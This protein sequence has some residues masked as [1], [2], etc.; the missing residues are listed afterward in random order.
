MGLPKKKNDISVYG[1]PLTQVSEIMDRR[2][3]LLERITNSDTF[4]PESILHDDL[5]AGMLSYIKENLVVTS[6]GDQIP[7]IPRI[8]T[9]QRWGEYTN[10]WTF[11]DDSG[12]LKLP[13]I[14]IV[15][16]PE[17]KLGTNP[18]VQ[19]TIPDRRQIFYASVPTWD[20]N[21]LGA[22]IYKIP[23]PIAVDINYDIYIVCTS[24]RDTNKF[25]KKIMELFPSRQSYTSVKGHYIPIVLEGIDDETPMETIDDRRF[26][27]QRYSFTMLG[28]LIDDEEFEVQPA[29]NRAIMMT[30]FDLDS[31]GGKL[32]LPENN[33]SIVSNYSGTTDTIANYEVTS[34]YKVDKDVQISFTD[35]IDSSGSP[36]I[37]T[38]DIFIER[39]NTSGSLSLSDPTD[40]SGLTSSNVFSGLTITPIGRSKYNYPFTKESNYL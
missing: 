22:D 9:I 31:N 19:R 33:I 6:N 30:E 13:F 3:E 10:N 36:V 28:F 40:Y 32:G 21:Q 16:K 26:Y 18:A 7:I 4:L 12:N 15:R 35:V 11:S 2:K 24:I 20:G 25:N 29:L 14:S 17:V 1:K 8:L 38:V 39:G 23:Q 27:L 37:L 34:E 5:D